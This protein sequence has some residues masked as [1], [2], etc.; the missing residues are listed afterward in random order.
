[1]PRWTAVAKN[2]GDAV[3]PAK[4]FSVRAVRERLDLLLAYFKARD[5]ANLK[6]SGTEEQYTEKTHLLQEIWDLAQAHGYVIKKKKEP[7]AAARQAA[8]ALRDTAAASFQPLASDVDDS[9]LGTPSLSVEEAGETA[10]NL[11]EEMYTDIPDLPPCDASPQAGPSGISGPSTTQKDDT[12]R[13]ARN[14]GGSRRKRTNTAAA[15]ADHEFLEK[16]W[17]H[18]AIKRKK[19]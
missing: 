3:V 12:G 2:V 19:L 7:S 9:E 6:K 18:E 10:Q 14:Q 1:M 15:N 11:L 4:T 17:F 13:T 16:R 8:A 5:E